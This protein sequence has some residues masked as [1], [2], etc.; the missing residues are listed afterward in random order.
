MDGGSDARRAAGERCLRGGQP[1]SAAEHFRAALRTDP[2]DRELLKLLADALRTGG[3]PLQACQVYEQMIRLGQATGEVWLALGDC[4][5]E[6]CEFAQ[7]LG[8]FEHSIKLQPHSPEAHHNHARALYRLGEVDAAVRELRKADRLGH[9]I[10]P[11]LSLATIIPGAPRAKQREIL[12]VRQQAAARLAAAEP[13]PA[14]QRPPRQNHGGPIRVAYLSA[15]FDS[16][17]YMKPVWAIVNHHDRQQFELHLLSDTDSSAAEMPGYRRH[18][19]DQLHRTSR[20]SNHELAGLVR[21]LG[22]DILVDLN[23][24]STPARLG[25]FVSPAAPVVVGWFNAYATYG[26]P[27]IDGIIGDDAVVSGSDERQF[28]ERVIRLPLS[29]LTFT[30]EHE[31]PPVAPAPCLKGSHFTFGSLVAQY[32][33][34]PPTIAAWSKILRGAP[35]SRLLLA[36]RALGSAENCAWLAGRFKHHGIDPERLTLLPPAP[37]YQYLK[38]YDRIALALDAFPYNGGTTTM[39]A[40]WQGVPVLAFDGDRWASRT[41]QT[42]LRRT[43]L[44]EFLSPSRRAMIR[45][46]IRLARDPATP[47]LLARIRQQMRDHLRRSSA[48]DAATAAGAIEQVYHQLIRGSP[49]SS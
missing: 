43:H 16:A 14:W 5:F 44:G 48:C 34:T 18:P 38:Y 31:A 2:H 47:S 45:N 20:L 24:Y 6:L 11:I 37:H 4:L 21:S 19:G 27:G 23:A 49:A 35:G 40:L 42:L 39:E 32:K 9:Q 36:N 25:L 3:K 33:I 13:Q 15:Y 8:A 17:N 7:S 30:V 26:M 12:A 41:S 22:I 10:E 1:E 29:Y 28:S 46:A